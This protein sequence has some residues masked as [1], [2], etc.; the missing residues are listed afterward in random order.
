MWDVAVTRCA[1]APK[2][3]RASVRRQS[4]AARRQR[5]TCLAKNTRIRSYVECTPTSDDM[6]YEAAFVLLFMLAK[7][8]VL[9]IIAEIVKLSVLVSRGKRWRQAAPECWRRRCAQVIG[10]SLKQ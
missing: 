2:A 7:I 3:S 9:G 10:G 1:R 5:R 8:Q 6:H 4:C